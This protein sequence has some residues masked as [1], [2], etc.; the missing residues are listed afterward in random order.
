MFV[1]DRRDPEEIPLYNNRVL[2]RGPRELLN[3]EREPQEFRDLSDAEIGNLAFQAQYQQSSTDGKNESLSV[4]DLHL[5]E[6]LLDKCVLIRCVQCWDTAENDGR[7][8]TL[9]WG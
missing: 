2:K 5:V 9:R 1:A 3:L 8:L 6:T 7:V 4:S